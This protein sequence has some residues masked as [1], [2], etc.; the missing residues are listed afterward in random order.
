MEAPALT[1]PAL[2]FLLTLDAMMTR[3]CLLCPQA[4]PIAKKGAWSLITQQQGRR[5]AVVDVSNGHDPPTAPRGAFS[6]ASIGG[7]I[8]CILALKQK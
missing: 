8:F 6:G 4:L 2:R 1:T 3:P 5:L 7:R